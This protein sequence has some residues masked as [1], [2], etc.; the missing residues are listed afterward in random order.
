MFRYQKCIVVG[1]KPTWV[2]TEEERQKRFRKVREKQQENPA[3]NRNSYVENEFSETTDT[4]EESIV[5]TECGMDED[6]IEENL[7]HEKIDRDHA[8][9]GQSFVSVQSSTPRISNTNNISI[10]CL[11]I[12]NEP[13]STM[14]PVYKEVQVRKSFFMVPLHLHFFYTIIYFMN[15]FTRTRSSLIS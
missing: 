12:K 15:N 5:E 14:S 2:L 9:V 13:I 7:L 10:Q 1:M 4:L 11:K 6:L 3:R 8:Y